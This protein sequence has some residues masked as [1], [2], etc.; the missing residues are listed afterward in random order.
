MKDTPRQ[1][2][3]RALKALGLGAGA[4]ALSSAPI[5]AQQATPVAETDTKPAGYRETPHVLSYYATARLS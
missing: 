4:A 2:R 5:Q 3:R 1:D